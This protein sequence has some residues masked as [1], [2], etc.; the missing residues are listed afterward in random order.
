MSD[1]DGGG[2]G[3]YNKSGADEEVDCR[4]GI[5]LSSDVI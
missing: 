2:G 5:I 3:E 4:V 1:R